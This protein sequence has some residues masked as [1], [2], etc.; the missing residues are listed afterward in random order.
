MPHS[1]HHRA[2]PVKVSILHDVAA[3]RSNGIK[4]R[5]CIATL[6]SQ[7]LCKP[8]EGQ[9]TCFQ[10][11]RISYVWQTFRHVEKLLQAGKQKAGREHK[12]GIAP[13]PCT[14]QKTR[15]S[16]NRRLWGAPAVGMACKTATSSSLFFLNTCTTA[17]L[18]SWVL[19][20]V[21]STQL[22]CTPQRCEAGTSRLAAAT[23]STADQSKP[24]KS[25]QLR[26]NH[27][28]VDEMRVRGSHLD[29]YY[30]KLGQW[31]PPGIAVA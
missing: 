21:G 16:H 2:L 18:N 6:Q 9:H 5:P 7:N 30:I 11:R 13:A 15:D 27:K 8:V 28:Y 14:S 31:K 12:R 29:S 4:A 24:L 25:L 26:R 20:V 3:K 10:V 23:I 1:C 22:T 17:A 19:P